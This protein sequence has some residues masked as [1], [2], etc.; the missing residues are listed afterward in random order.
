MYI[1]GNIRWR[2]ERGYEMTKRS[3][4]VSFIAISALLISIKYLSAA[5]Y[6]SGA[7]S[8]GEGLFE[9]NLSYVGN[10]LSNCSLL[11]LFIGIVYII[12]EEYE[13]LKLKRK[14]D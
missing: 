11:S 2:K 6:G 10:T 4:G 9:A 12:W 1:Y 5:I 13:E 8:W 7:L 3:T 14:S